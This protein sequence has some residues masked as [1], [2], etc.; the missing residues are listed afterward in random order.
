MI[1]MLGHLT[2]S[3]S[4]LR[5][6][7]LLLIL[8]SSL[9]H[10][11]PPFY[12]PT[13]L[14]SALLKL[15][16]CW[17][18]SECFW[19]QLL[20]YSLLIDSS[21]FLLGSFKIFLASSQSLSLIYLSVTSFCFQGCGSSVL[22]SFWILFQVDSL[23]PPLLFGLVGIYQIPLLAAYFFAFSFLLDCCVW[24]ALS[25]SWKFVVPLYCGA[26]SLW[27]VLD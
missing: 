21:S 16:S 12:L 10:L 15:F 18:P 3:Q 13:H 4:S 24:G 26:C 8:F 6:P 5:L 7:S 19:S 11:F 1:Q 25:I 22:S 27:V 23:S 2:L 17:F 14:S 9:L 20:H